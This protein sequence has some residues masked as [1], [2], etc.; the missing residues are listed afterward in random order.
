MTCWS[1]YLGSQACL[2]GPCACVSAT[3]ALRPRHRD[4]DPCQFQEL[5][6]DIRCCSFG[7]TSA[8]GISR[9][10]TFVVWDLIE[11]AHSGH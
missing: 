8:F 11:A 2:L 5:G 6:R 9:Y 3:S 1:K 7:A 4:R 10:Y